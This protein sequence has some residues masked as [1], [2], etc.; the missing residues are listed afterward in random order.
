MTMS[1]R[2][3]TSK[4]G[5][6]L[7]IDWKLWGFNVLKFSAPILAVFFG[8]LAQD[9]PVEKAW[10]IALLALYGA[11][12]DFFKKWKAETIYKK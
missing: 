2:Y 10:P 6:M 4:S 11:L 12:A 3:F 5:Q 7:P 1:L 8:M 9:V